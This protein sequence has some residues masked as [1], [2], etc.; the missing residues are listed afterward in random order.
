[1]EIT[2]HLFDKIDPVAIYAAIVATT[3]LVWDVI[4]WLRDGPRLHGSAGANMSIYDGSRRDDDLYFTLDV[5]NTGSKP[6]TITNFCH[7][8]HGRRKAVSPVSRTG[9]PKISVKKRQISR[10]NRVLFLPQDIPYVQPE[11]K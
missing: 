1:M 11:A 3:V 4:K 5:S 6:T 8:V 7:E 2:L 10:L 9:I